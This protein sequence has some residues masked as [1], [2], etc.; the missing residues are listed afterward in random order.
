MKCQICDNENLTKFLD[1]G[2]HPPPLNF[3][4]PQNASEQK[5]FPL[6]VFHCDSCGLVQLGNAV[7]PNLMF[8]EYTYTSGVST[9][10]K[11]HLHE[12]AAYLVKRFDLKENDLV[13]DIASNDGTLL[14]GFKK[15]GIKVLG[16]EPSN[17]ADIAI[18]NNIPTIN[19]FFNE[20]VANR[21]E[22]DF[23]KAKI[24]TA[25]NVFAHV[26]KLDSFMKGIKKILHENG[27]FVSES[28]YLYDIVTKLE[29]DTIY[30]EHLRYYGLKQLI[31]LF[32]KYEMDVFD[33]ERI[34]AQ[35][36][37]IRAFACFKNK[38]KILPSIQKI[39]KNEDDIKI[40]S[41]DTMK[42]FARRIEDNKNKLR[43]L[44]QQL[45]AEGKTIVGIGAPARSSTVLNYCQIG[46]DFLD[47]V[48]EKSQ[49]KIGKLTPGTHIKVVD[50]D[51]LSK[52]NPDYA[53]LLSW[54]LKESIIPKIRDG[55]FKG[56]LIIPL[57]NVEIL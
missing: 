45:K 28:Q 4:M 38:F 12:F 24:I 2:K 55:G 16:V 37:S 8:K 19:D 43:S 9:A 21:I 49:L 52:V 41:L 51:E 40:S 57:P 13:I 1:L 27:S 48:A 32:N 35:G 26:D 15:F 11:K 14:D 53:L 3:V 29:Y 34:E 56:K 47:F 25:T 46:P 33:A 42:E 5:L 10:F 50:D 20:E 31:F 54:H 30:H 39:V 23:G 17:T 44:L 36:G 22:Q 7:D 18:K 6:E